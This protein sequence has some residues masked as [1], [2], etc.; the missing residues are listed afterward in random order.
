MFS[1]KGVPISTV[2]VNIYGFLQERE[3]K[4]IMLKALV[5]GREVIR[6]CGLRLQVSSKDKSLSLGTFS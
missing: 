4:G 3:K 5:I 1:T 2:R 6:K